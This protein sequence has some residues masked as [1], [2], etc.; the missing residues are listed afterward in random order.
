MTGACQF[1][2][3]SDIAVPRQTCSLGCPT[4]VVYPARL[5][6]ELDLGL[7]K[8]LNAILLGR[9]VDVD[10]VTALYQFDERMFSLIYFIVC[11]MSS[12]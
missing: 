4:V 10:R 5:W 12:R 8:V 9:D 11:G 1:T 3:I 6:I 7:N 2:V